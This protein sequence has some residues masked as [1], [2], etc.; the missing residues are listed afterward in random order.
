[1]QDIVE[2]TAKFQD[3]WSGDTFAI[4]DGVLDVGEMR[5]HA[6]RLLKIV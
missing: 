5:P 2:E 3:V 1:L 6:S 4:S